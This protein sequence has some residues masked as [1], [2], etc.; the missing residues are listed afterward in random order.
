MSRKPIRRRKRCLSKSYYNENDPKMAAWLR[1]LIAV[2]LIAPGDVDERSILDVEAKD[3][4][5]YTQCHFF[6]GIGGWSYA[7]RLAGW[8]DDRPIWTG[9]L[10]CQPFSVAGKGLA[11]RDER[12]LWP[13]F[14][15]LVSECRPTTCCGEQVASKAGRLWL[16][17]VR[18]DL[19][20]MGY[21]VGAADLPAAGVGSP[22]RRQRLFWVANTASKGGR[23][24]EQIREGG[25]KEPGRAG[26]TRGLADNNSKRFNGEPVCLFSGRSQQES[27]ETAG[28]GPSRGL[29]DL[30]NE[31][32]QG[33]YGGNLQ[34]CSRQYAAGKSSFDCWSRS[35]WWPCA[36][37]KWRR[38]PANER[39]K[40]ESVFQ[41]MVVG[42]PD[43]VDLSGPEGAF[44]L[45]GKVEGRVVLLRGYGNAICPQ[46]AAAFIRAF[47]ETALE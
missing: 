47:M 42:I 4:Q 37:E 19:E 18:A 8:P 33:R 36:D 30:Y 44:P 29:A 3:L 5:G 38:V 11:E 22:Q 27:I 45:A 15:R 6:A 46:V 32:P 21:A 14:R 26:P 24:R 10:P 1:E 41:R 17:G 9:S 20:A 16:T 13:A 43:S 40:V 25:H 35:A 12:H 2:G 34:E 28:C 39:E 7:L 23:G 31:R